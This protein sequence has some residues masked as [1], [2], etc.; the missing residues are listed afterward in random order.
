MGTPFVTPSH[1]L[2]P[3]PP[4]LA[5]QLPAL[6]L[7]C[8]MDVDVERDM[9]YRLHVAKQVKEYTEYVRALTQSKA[10]ASAQVGG[11][12]QGGEKDAPRELSA[13]FHVPCTHALCPVPVPQQV[14]THPQT[15]NRSSVPDLPYRL[16]TKSSSRTGITSTTAPAASFT[17]AQSGT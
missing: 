15:L 8:D 6:V 11:G 17:R 14:K 4:P 16:A 9:E 7:D 5:V 2:F 12:G 3:L 10:T 1:P 13:P